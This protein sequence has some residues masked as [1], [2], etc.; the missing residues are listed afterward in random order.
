MCI[1]DSVTI[2]QII[3]IPIAQEVAL[4]YEFIIKNDISSKPIHAI[5]TFYKHETSNNKL[6]SRPPI[7]TILGHVDHGKTTLL[8]SILNTNVVTQE[9]GG[10]TQSISNYEIEFLHETQL[11]KLIFLDTPGHQAFSSIRMRG[12][13]VTDLVLLIVAADDGLKPQTIECINYIFEQN[14]PYIVVINKIDKIGINTSK[15]K[16][17]LAQ[18][19]IMDESWGG[20]AIITEVS[21]LKQKNLDQLLTNICLLADLQDLKANPK[22]AAIGT[23]IETYL[24]IRKGPVVVLV[25]Q[26]GSLKIGD[27]IVSGNLYGKVKMIVNNAGIKQDVVQPSSI[28]Q[29]LGFS[30]LPKAGESFY[31]VNNK[32]SAEN[33]VNNY[34]SSYQINQLNN[35]NN[36]ITWESIQTK[37]SIKNLNLILKA[38]AQGSSE[39]IINSFNSI[40][41][42]KV[43]INILQLNFGNISNTDLS[44]IHI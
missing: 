17:E 38:D 20:D 37:G 26:N 18:Y 25:V 2:N 7:I 14:L 1:R 23:I 30:N 19:N 42:E 31:V 33:A 11:H 15:V 34:K 4:K 44:L 21:A 39:A 22:Q 5:K 3:D 12:T 41:Q 43:Q 32:K 8:D 6:I 24:D 35:L 28:V 13:L 10:I 16:E 27:L 29:V 36:R 9:V 40:S